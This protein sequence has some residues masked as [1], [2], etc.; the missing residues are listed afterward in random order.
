MEAVPSSEML[1]KL[2]QTTQ[3]QIAENSRDTLVFNLDDTLENDRYIC[4]VEV[5]S[6][7]IHGVIYL[8]TAP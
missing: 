3:R 7:F 6:K 8:S 4:Q 2:Y 1:V 5:K